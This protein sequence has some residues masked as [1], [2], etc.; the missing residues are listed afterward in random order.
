MSRSAAASNAILQKVEC[1]ITKSQST[2][3]HLCSAASGTPSVRGH[4]KER[5]R[6]TN[7][8]TFA[9]LRSSR[10][11]LGE[12]QGPL[13][14][15]QCRA[16]E[17]SWTIVLGR[18]SCTTFLS[19]FAAFNSKTILPALVVFNCLKAGEVGITKMRPTDHGKPGCL[20]LDNERMVIPHPQVP[21]I[22]EP[23]PDKPRNARGPT[24]VTKM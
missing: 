12:V 3:M 17:N 22:A 15:N 24:L 9:C 18:D 8:R 2:G 14:G 5:G 1:D 7:P 23:F 13:T 16:I 21:A 4:T 6:L 10:S 20:Q 19:R 11:R